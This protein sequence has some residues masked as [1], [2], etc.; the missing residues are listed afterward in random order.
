M[1]LTFYHACKQFFFYLKGIKAEKQLPLCF[2]NSGPLIK[3]DLSDTES[4]IQQQWFIVGLQ[5]PQEA[6][7]NGL[8]TVG[9]LTRRVRS[10]NPV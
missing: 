10:D 1:I 2:P 9:H 6:C 8:G 3:N 5:S 4:F 7:H